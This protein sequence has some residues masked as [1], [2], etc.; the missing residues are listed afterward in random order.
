MLTSSNYN[1]NE[2]KVTGGRNGYGAK[3]ANIYSTKFIVETADK[4]SKKKYKQEFS[5]NMMVF[6]KPTI[7][8]N[9]KGQEYT[10]ITFYPE[11][12]RFAGM[13]EFNDDFIALV[14]KRVFDMAGK[15]RCFGGL[16]DV[17]T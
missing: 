4:H 7:T 10:K 1:D 8:E 16:S 17:L 12:H 5:K 6:G 11:L 13:T 2:K 15:C 9:S 3:L 14:K